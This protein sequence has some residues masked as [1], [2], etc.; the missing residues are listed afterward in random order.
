M[1]GEEHGVVLEAMPLGEPRDIRPLADP[2]ML[3]ST[4]MVV[5]N[6]WN[7]SDFFSTKDIARGSSLRNRTGFNKQP[8]ENGKN[9][10]SGMPKM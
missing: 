6:G 3:K 8:T 5:E 9:Q 4:L 10:R 2:G 7:S 1:Q